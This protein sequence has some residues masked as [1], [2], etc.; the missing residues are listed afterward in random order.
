MIGV[1]DIYS[2]YCDSASDINEHLPTIRKYC[3]ECE[4][5]TEFGTRT[6]VSTVA[7]LASK[8]KRFITYDISIQ[9]YQ[10]VEN[11]VTSL[12]KENNIDFQFIQADDL[13]I[14]IEKTDLLFIDTLHVYDQLYSELIKHASCVK[15]YIIMHDTMT[16]GQMDEMYI[17]SQEV[18]LIKAYQNFLLT[19]EGK[20]WIVLEIYNNNNGLTILKRKDQLWD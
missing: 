15:K 14:N 17:G 3:S 4:H 2:I 7:M 13:K 18:G 16:Y 11:I 8:P 10:K 6:G 20:N 19:E 1:E 9:D 5:I 12:A